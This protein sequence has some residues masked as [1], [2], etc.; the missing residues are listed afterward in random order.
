[1]RFPLVRRS[2]LTELEKLQGL[3]RC[4]RCKKLIPLG[5][6]HARANGDPDCHVVYRGKI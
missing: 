6:A 4:R 3:Y 5:W 1:M 2:R